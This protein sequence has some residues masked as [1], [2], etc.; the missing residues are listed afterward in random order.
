MLDVTKSLPEDPD[1]LRAFTMLL[2]A[3]VKAQAVLSYP[4]KIG[5]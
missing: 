2:V 5:Q 4:P 3:E 1:E